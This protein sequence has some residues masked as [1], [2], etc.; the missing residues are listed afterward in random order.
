MLTVKY[1][2]WDKQNQTQLLCNP[3]GPNKNAS[4]GDPLRIGQRAT[5]TIGGIQIKILLSE[6]KSSSSSI[7]RIIRILDQQND[8]DVLGN[9]SIG[10]TVFISRSDMKS[11]DVDVP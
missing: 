9:L 10:D 4:I 11:L 3:D 5:G 7:G 6:L 8:L 2:K 1:P